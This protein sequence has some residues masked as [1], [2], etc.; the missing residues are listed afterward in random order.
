MKKLLYPLLLTALAFILMTAAFADSNVTA[1]VETVPSA[2]DS[3]ALTDLVTVLAASVMG[4][5]ALIIR[6]G[7]F[8]SALRCLSPAAIC[9]AIFCF[10]ENTGAK[11]TIADSWTPVLLAVGAISLALLIGS[12]VSGSAA[13]NR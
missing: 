6:G 10:T 13:E 3:W 2:A 12:G 7:G 5:V 11:M 8:S 9:A 1:A 4:T